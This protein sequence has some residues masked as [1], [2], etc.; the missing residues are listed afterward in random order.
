MAESSDPDRFLAGWTGAESA[1][2][3]EA[4]SSDPDQFH[5]GWTEWQKVL[6][7]IV[8]TRVGQGQTALIWTGAMPVRQGHTALIRTSSKFDKDVMVQT[9]VT[10]G[11]PD[12]FHL[13]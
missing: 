5:A 11:H 10:W 9:L 13:L 8:S 6:I 12:S 2:Q 3:T 7:Q 4:D 1:G